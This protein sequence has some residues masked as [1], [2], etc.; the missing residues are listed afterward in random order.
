ME[1]TP[2]EFLSMLSTCGIPLKLKATP[3]EE[4]SL[5]ILRKVGP[6]YGPLNL[7]YF[8]LNVPSDYYRVIHPRTIPLEQLSKKLMLNPQK[9]P[10][11]EHQ[12]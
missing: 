9:S 3:E 7:L 2:A 4:Q 11:K 1:T 12:D 10:I 6:T 5:H 8:I